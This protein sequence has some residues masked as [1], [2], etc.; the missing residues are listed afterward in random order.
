M[1]RFITAFEVARAFGAA[2]SSVNR[3][4]DLGSLRI[5]RTPDGLRRIA[6]GDVIQFARLD[7]RRILDPEPLGLAPSCDLTQPLKLEHGA[8]LLNTTMTDRADGPA[9]EIVLRLYMSGYPV[10]RICDEAIRPSFEYVR[11]GCIDG[12]VAQ[13]EEQRACELCLTVLKKMQCILPRVPSGAPLAAGCTP[14]GDPDSI[15]TAMIE[16]ALLEAGWHACTI[17]RCV[18]F[19]AM[20]SVVEALRPALFW[21]SASSVTAGFPFAR[22]T[23]LFSE[24]LAKRDI[25]LVIRGDRFDLRTRNRVPHAFSG[26]SLLELQEYAKSLRN[27]H[28]EGETSGL[29]EESS[30]T[31]QIPDNGNPHC[32][33]IPQSGNALVE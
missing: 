33:E 29:N 17:G 30:S 8:S 1:R 12:R 26:Q 28:S 9:F 24:H 31:A 16:V 23:R 10:G 3:W 19:D 4:C 7:H 11:N 13:Y 20:H 25:P 2:V 32:R 6:A 18:P 5:A 14:P 15:S 22:H 27:G 21:L